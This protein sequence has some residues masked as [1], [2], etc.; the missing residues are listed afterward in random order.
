MPS[1][2]SFLK[3]I[4]CTFGVMLM[5]ADLFNK[6]NTYTVE[7]DIESVPKDYFMFS[8]TLNISEIT[9]T[10]LVNKFPPL[11]LLWVSVAA[12]RIFSCDVQTLSGGMW[13]LVP[14]AGLC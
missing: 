11:W 12:C 9:V 1:Q 3:I 10:L 2:P 14:C 7:R 13:D 6:N 4:C 5:I 8:E